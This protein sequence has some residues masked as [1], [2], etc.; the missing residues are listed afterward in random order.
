MEDVAT[1]SMAMPS[2][3]GSFWGDAVMFLPMW[4]VMMAAM[5]LPSM[6]PMVLTFSAV[7]HRRRANSG[8]YVPTWVF[9]SG[10]AIIWASTGVPGYLAKAGLDALGDHLANPAPAAAL[11]GGL[12][13]IGAGLYQLS[14]AK[15]R[16]LSHCRTPFGFI[17][18]GWREGYGGALQMGLRHGL[19]CLGCC[20]ALMAVLFPVG[21]MNL[22]WM[23]GLAALVFL[24]KLSPQGVWLARGSGLTL[25]VA[26]AFLA[27][28]IL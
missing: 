4:S 23:G 28:G 18:Q 9:L 6:L 8:A 11:A 10:Y 14:P 27:T 5:M 26:G 2:D 24:E 7:Y 20:W 15:D 1:P 17:M 13:L 19:Y 3:Q 12:V 22:A 25:I 16:C 21:V